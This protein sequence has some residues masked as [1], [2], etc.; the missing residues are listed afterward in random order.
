MNRLF[1]GS[2]RDFASPFVDGTVVVDQDVA[3]D[4]GSFARVPVM[5]GATGADLGGPDGVMVAG[6]RKIANKI[7]AQGVPVYAYR[8]SYVAESG[9]QA[10]G[11][12]HATDVPFFLGTE[13]IRYGD[14]TTARDIRVGR[15]ASGYMVNVAR[16]GD[17]NG[18]GFP[19][20]RRY[21]AV[22]DE[23]MDFAG[24]GAAVL[25]KDPWN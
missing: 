20:W 9:D 11:A 5:I 12:Q 10:A 14:Q 25:Q 13:S 8:F 22:S 3:Y 19:Y 23:I 24:D 18:A 6:A 17:P 1:D 21:D 16:A 2:P 15:L 4:A 7:A